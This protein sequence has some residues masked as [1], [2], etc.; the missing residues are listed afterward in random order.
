MVSASSSVARPARELLLAEAA[1]AAGTPATSE[2]DC[3]NPMPLASPHP[4][5][6]GIG[7]VRALAV[8]AARG[9]RGSVGS[10][11]RMANSPAIPC[12]DVR[13]L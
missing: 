12:V 7:T 6:D 11:E 5:S 1:A 4:H 2:R 8:S 10:S 3:Q 9:D 13:V